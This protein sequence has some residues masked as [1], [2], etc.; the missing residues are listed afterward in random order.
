MQIKKNMIQGCSKVACDDMFNRSF[1]EVL[2]ISGYI[3]FQH[4]SKVHKGGVEE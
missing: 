4:G 3:N 1:Y 2:Q